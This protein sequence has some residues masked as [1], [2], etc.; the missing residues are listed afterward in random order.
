VRHLK[1]RRETTGGRFD[2]GGRW[3]ADL[4]ALPTAPP[5]TAVLFTCWVPTARDEPALGA[6]AFEED[7]AT[8]LYPH[9]AREILASRTGQVLL[10][11]PRRDA[12]S[13][14]DPRQSVEAHGN[15]AGSPVSRP[16]ADL[17]GRQDIA[18][19]ED[20]D[21]RGRP[22]LVMTH[23]VPHTSWVLLAKVDR[24]EALSP[25]LRQ[26]WQ[27]I[28][29]A[30]GILLASLGGAFGLWRNRQAVYMRERLQLEERLRHSQKMEAIGRLAGG[31][32]HDFN[33]LLTVIAG[34]A[35]AA[36]RTTDPDRRS[37]ELNEIVRASDRAAALTRQ[38]LAFSRK[39]VLQSRV[40]DLNEIVRGIEPLLRP[41]IGE[42]IALSVA[43][44]PAPVLTKADP[45]QIEQVVVNLAVNARDAMP[46][47]GTLELATGSVVL[48]KHRDGEPADLE[49]GAYVTLTVRD[50]GVGISPELQAQVFEPFFTTKASGKGTGLGLATVY[51]IVK[52]S[53]GSIGVES[54]PGGGTTFRV[55]LPAADEPAER[56]SPRGATGG[57]RRAA[58]RETVLLVEDSEGVRTLV[59]KALERDG[60][61]VLPAGD[62]E[63][64]VR[65][66]ASSGTIDLLLTDVVLPGVNGRE[67]ARKAAADRPGLRV[68]YMSG[69]PAEII[70]PDASAG[71]SFIGKPFTAAGIASKVRNT[72]DGPAS[73]A[74]A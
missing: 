10:V 17:V 51:G 54:R 57:E 46:Q 42:P 66:L 2:A 43:L 60:Y 50:T 70:G 21:D 65:L 40:I 62:A 3:S 24:D 49:P 68:L 37:R 26:A 69:Y 44:A 23:P 61:T 20:M 9:L 32:A 5:G 28:A 71:V 55:F 59:Q 12:V 1:G 22:V 8:F 6:I 7:P 18:F 16:L 36:L 45:G 34:Y 63:E 41:L 47:G 4:I 29:T 48:G 53:G 38:L 74:Q 11:V 56:E 35:D 30:A 72:L 13:T 52:Q 39:Q 14:V 31:V 73:S 64:A 19:W 25:S 58:G 33:N 67:L 15:R 27:G